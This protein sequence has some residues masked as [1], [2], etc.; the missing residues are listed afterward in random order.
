MLRTRLTGSKTR[1]L[2]SL[3]LMKL[4]LTFAELS[5]FL[6]FG[7]NPAPFLNITCYISEVK[8]Q[9]SNTQYELPILHD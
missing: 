7:K 9:L 8:L 2:S 1:L 3:E 4:N 6:M 5:E